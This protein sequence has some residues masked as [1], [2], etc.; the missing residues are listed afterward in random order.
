MKGEIESIIIIGQGQALNMR[1]HQRNMNQRIDSKC[2]MCSEV[3]HIKGDAGWTK[4]ATSEYTNGH[5]KVVGYIHWTICKHMGLQVTDRYCEHLPERVRNVNRPTIVW[6][7][8]V[9]TVLTVL[10][11][12]T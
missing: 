12:P 1:Y 6:D 11:K 7:V 3:E 8:Q 4:P 9:I 10:S 5:D 2:R